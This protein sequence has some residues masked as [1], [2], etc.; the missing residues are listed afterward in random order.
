MSPNYSGHPQ[1][2][3]SFQQAPQQDT[4]VLLEESALSDVAQK[5]RDSVADTLMIDRDKIDLDADLADFGVDSLLVVNLHRALEE[6]V[7]TLPA[8]LF[9]NNQSP[10]EVA[11]YLIAHHVEQ[12]QQLLGT[13]A[14]VDPSPLPDNRVR[15]ATFPTT[16]VPP[17]PLQE[18]SKG[19]HAP[20]LFSGAQRVERARVLR[21]ISP[22]EIQPFLFSYG[23]LFREGKLANAE[24]MAAASEGS[25]IQTDHLLHL[26]VDVPSCSQV[27]VFVIGQGAPLVFMPA[28]AL[29]APVWLKQIEA[30]SDQYCLM[31][32][33]APGYGLSKGIRESNTAG[34]SRV[35][36][37]VLQQLLGSQPAHLVASCFGSI[38]A[39]HLTRFNPHQVASLTMVGG[40]YD[41]ADLP[42]VEADKLSIEEV[43]QM[44]QTVSGSLKRDFDTV[45]NQW[46]TDDP[47]REEVEK[48]G[49]LLVGSQCVSPLVAMRYLNEMMT[50][51]TLEWISRLHV[52]V[53]FVF[54]DLDTVIRPVHAQTMHEALG[55]S[56][57]IEI[58]G[59][60]HYPFL[61]HPSLFNAVLLDFLQQ[62]EGTHPSLEANESPF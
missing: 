19:M 43:M 59:S 56:R 50:L 1:T 57:L 61:T 39:T 7:G 14:H 5:V 26:L 13:S 32:I 34:V 46:P 25:R 42:P 45:A 47:R 60:G 28:I 12:A 16:A 9:L 20:V 38:V 49:L 10:R 18:V 24:P 21:R 40:F 37:E 22:T 58:K 41:G 30:L 27:E 53:S 62:V 4:G 2:N 15:N 52:P 6:R 33:H 54:G 35:F 11:A 44:V 29:T 3:T 8:T 48:M 17:A 31:V 23:E 51:S 55:H 36:S